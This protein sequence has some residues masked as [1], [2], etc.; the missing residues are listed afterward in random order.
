MKAYTKPAIDFIELRPEERL[1]CTS[2]PGGGGCCG[3][4]GIPD[5]PK[6][7]PCYLWTHVCGK[8]APFFIFCGIFKPPFRLW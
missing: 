2:G 8:S 6:P 7:S 5:W 1:A 3:G 4:G